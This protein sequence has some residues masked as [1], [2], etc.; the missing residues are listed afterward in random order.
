MFRGN[1]ATYY[2]AGRCASGYDM[3]LFGEDAYDWHMSNASMFV[4]RFEDFYFFF[5]QLFNVVALYA[6]AF[7]WLLVFFDLLRA[8][9][10]AALGLTTL[11]AVG[12]R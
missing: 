9:A 12:L 6:C 1:V 10:D 3:I 8:E 11:T 2:N 5:L 4:F 7:V